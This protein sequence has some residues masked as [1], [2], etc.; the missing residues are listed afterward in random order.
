MK[1][2]KALIWASIGMAGLGLMGCYFVG[3]GPGVY[4]GPEEP[5]Y[6][7]VGVAPPPLIVEQRP[8]PPSA[9]HIWIDGYWHWNGRY[10]WERGHWGVP[11]R[12]HATWI[13]PRYERHDHGYRYAPGHWKTEKQEDRRDGGRGR[14]GDQRQDR[15]DAPGRPDRK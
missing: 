9:L 2:L 15:R 13:A 10:V 3:G 12:G 14:G 6:V 1:V 8:L 5:A 4:V 11:P 7:E